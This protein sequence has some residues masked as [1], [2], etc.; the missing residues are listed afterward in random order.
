M[1]S[2]ATPAHLGW[3]A[4]VLPSAPSFC[5]SVRRQV[6]PA[7]I[8]DRLVAAWLRGNTDLSLN[9]T[10]WSVWTYERY[11]ETMFAWAD[12]LGV[13]ADELE[14][15]IFSEQAELVGSQWTRSDQA[16]ASGPGIPAAGADEL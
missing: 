1:G 16:P 9:E 7:L 11:L 6:D 3:W 15:C 5:T 8:L 4:W 12:E 2:W 10:R 13:A 14:A